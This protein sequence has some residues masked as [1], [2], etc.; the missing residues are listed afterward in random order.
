M[1]SVGEEGVC[2][3][4]GAEGVCWCSIQQTVQCNLFLLFTFF[5]AVSNNQQTVQCN[6]FLFTFLIMYHCYVCNCCCDTIREFR[7]HLQHHKDS[8]ELHVPLM[9]R[10]DRC[11]SSYTT[12]FNF[13]RHIQ[14]HHMTDCETEGTKCTLANTRERNNMGDDDEHDMPNSCVMPEVKDKH[15]FLLDMQTEGVSL[16]AGLRANSSIPY[17]VI[18]GLMEHFNNMAGSLTSFIET[19]VLDGLSSVGVDRQA[20]DKVSTTL[21]EKLQYCRK[22]FDF[23]SSR[24]RID[25]FFADHP[26]MSKPEPV[27]FVPR[28]ESHCGTSGFVYDQFQYVSVKKTL[29][30]LLQSSSYVEALLQ[31]KCRPG[32]L[33]SFSDGSRYREHY[34][35]GNCS[36]LSLMLQLFYDGLGVTNPLRS[37]GSAHNVGVFYYTV[38]NLPQEFNSCFANVHLLA[39]SYTHD[40][41]L[42][43]FEPILDKFI[44]EIKELSTVGFEGVFPILGKCTVYASLCQVTCDNLALNSLLGFV[45]SFS[46]SYFCTICYATKADIQTKFREEYFSIRSVAEY[47]K[48]LESLVSVKAGKNHYRGV[49]YNCKLNEI[50]GFHVTDNW[51]LDIMHTLLEGVIIVELGCILH[52]LCVLDK[53]LSLPDINKAFSVLWGKITVDKTHKPVEITGILEPGLVI[54]PSMKAVQS[55]ALLKYLPLAVGKCVPSKNKHWEFLLHLSHMVDLIFAPAFTEEM[56]IYLKDVISDH[57]SRFRDLYSSE[58]VRLRPKHHFLVHLPSIVLKSGPLVG[59]SCMPYELKNSFFKRCAHIVCNFTNICR[60]LA[61][62]HQQQSMFAQLSNTHIRNV[63][64]VGKHYY[65]YVHTLPYCDS[66]CE[67]LDVEATE[68]V[69]ISKSLH[70]ATMEYKQ[71]HFVVLCIDNNTGFPTFGK[72]ISFVSLAGDDCWH[73]VLEHMPTEDFAH[74]FHSYEVT[75]VQPCV[76][77]VHRLR[78]L[79]DH[80]P[81]YCHSL[82]LGSSKRQYLRLPY[83]IF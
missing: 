43:G 61:H 59:M 12:L 34:L 67:K 38:R 40:I 69:A 4:V 1:E 20:I 72:I 44:A 60:T 26:S 15:D 49:K 76:F 62:R 11:K 18:P 41:A 25:S 14:S 27:H 57:L 58:H 32:V 78:D 64:T 19:E 74:H 42:Y 8:A 51:S 83:H 82:L 7:I 79:A 23:F 35:F 5:G 68:Q 77:M 54:T 13:L 29:S 47:N 63:V 81:L 21:D 22:P 16:V 50:P 36:K 24:Y 9:C 56:A 75:T 39:L 53:C 80:H 48:D 73:V 17:S 30:N 3:S 33:L 6:L 28:L 2:E 31:D 71:G 37:Q 10:Q 70:V 65:E 66:L 46:G 55:W 52:G 45:E